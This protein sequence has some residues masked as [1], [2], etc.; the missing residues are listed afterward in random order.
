MCVKKI[1]AGES[2]GRMVRWHQGRVQE[3]HCCW[4]LNPVRH[5]H[6]HAEVG[7][8]GPRHDPSALL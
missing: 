5:K 2:W 6:D 7:A 8:L 1:I 4:D 3:G